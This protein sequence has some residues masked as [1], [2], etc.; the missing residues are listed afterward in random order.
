MGTILLASAFESMIAIKTKV[1][2]VSVA[3]NSLCF[4]LVLRLVACTF[5][6]VATIGRNYDFRCL[7]RNT[8]A[9]Q[10]LVAEMANCFA[11]CSLS[12]TCDQS[13]AIFV[14]RLLR[15]LSRSSTSGVV[16]ACRSRP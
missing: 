5:A 14:C 12:I 10:Q 2:V 9:I 11:R 6:H 1:A 16:L 15:L 4:H 7:M 3:P 8:I 13:P